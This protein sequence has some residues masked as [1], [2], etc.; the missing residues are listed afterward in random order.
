MRGQRSNFDRLLSGESPNSEVCSRHWHNQPDEPCTCPK[1]K[2]KYHVVEY[3]GF[4]KIQEGDKYGDVD[5]LNA[6]DVGYEQAKANA[7]RIVKLLN[8]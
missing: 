2:P 8:L 6:E 5:I 3:A 1:N 4:F 7:E